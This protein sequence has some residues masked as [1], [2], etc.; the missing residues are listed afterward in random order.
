MRKETNKLKKTSKKKVQPSPEALAR[1]KETLELRLKQQR[2]QD[3][4]K[5]EESKRHDLICGA[6]DVHASLHGARWG[7][8]GLP[9]GQPPPLPSHDTVAP[10]TGGTASTPASPLHPVSANISSASHDDIVIESLDH[11]VKL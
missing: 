8:D 9:T 7:S 1:R 4:A 5:R 2:L 3:A 10:F 6:Q 11:D